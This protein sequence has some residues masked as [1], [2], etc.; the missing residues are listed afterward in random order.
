LLPVEVAHKIYEN[1]EGRAS[2]TA[3]PM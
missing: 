3:R 1:A 2:R